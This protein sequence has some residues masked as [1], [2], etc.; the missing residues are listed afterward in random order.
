MQQIQKDRCNVAL[1][2]CGG[3]GKTTYMSRIITGDF[4]K[5]YIP[6]INFTTTMIDGEF[7]E[8]KTNFTVFDT[9][10][11]E[12]YSPTPSFYSEMDAFLLFFD[13]TSNIS[14]IRCDLWLKKIMEVQTHPKIILIGSKCDIK[15]Q[16]QHV[17]YTS[18]E[19]FLNT[20]GGKYN[21]YMKYYDISAKS[22][23]QF[24]KPFKEL[25]RWILDN[26]I[27]LKPDNSVV[28]GTC[29]ENLMCN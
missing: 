24:E 25:D 20:V 7:T 5:R 29:G 14:L 18:I 27:Q 19:K 15:H 26:R 13:L 10:G 23:Y 4:E 12:M 16:E 22:C 6:T 1:V 11:Q 9:A 21:I 8:T 2:G 17:S 3:T 28:E